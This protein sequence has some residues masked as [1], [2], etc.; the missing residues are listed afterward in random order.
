LHM[1]LEAVPGCSPRRSFFCAR[2]C[3]DLARVEP[4]DTEQSQE[5]WPNRQFGRRRQLNP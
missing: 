1:E 4:P 3:K 5:S 2:G